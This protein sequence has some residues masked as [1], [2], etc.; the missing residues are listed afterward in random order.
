MVLQSGCWS[1]VASPGCKTRVCWYGGEAVT[2]AAGLPPP[3]S[4]CWKS[5]L[6]RQ[7]LIWL[8][9]APSKELWA[10]EFTSKLVKEGTGTPNLETAM[11]GA[12]EEPPHQGQ[13]RPQPPE[14]EPGRMSPRRWV[15]QSRTYRFQTDRHSPLSPEAGFFQDQVEGRVIIIKYTNY[16]IIIIIIIIII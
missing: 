6:E 7:M 9:P 3:F 5:P 16:C 10:P 1:G 15:S 13:E 14:A 8:I 11:V 12:G 4:W 2:Q